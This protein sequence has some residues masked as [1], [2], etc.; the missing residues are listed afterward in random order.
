MQR[1]CRCN[2]I[3][4]SIGTTATAR[5][6]PPSTKCQRNSITKSIGT[7]ATA[8]VEA[9]CEESVRATASPCSTLPKAS[10]QQQLLRSRLPAKKM[11]VQQHHHA[12]PCQ[13]HWH[14]SNC[15][16]HDLLRRKCQ[17]NSITES[18]G[19]TAAARVEASRKET[20]C[21]TASPCST[22]PFML[23]CGAALSARSGSPGARARRQPRVRD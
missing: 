7:T 5:V 16:G 17:R 21:A 3:S 12:Q 13:E 23:P 22:L 14:N 8:K 1:K 4:E 19:T 20:V 18:I 15:Q 10:A 11:S 9:S 2:S 6:E